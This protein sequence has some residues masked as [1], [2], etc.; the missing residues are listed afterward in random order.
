MPKF[1]IHWEHGPCAGLDVFS[2]T[3]KGRTRPAENAPSY[4][5]K[6][7]SPFRATVRPRTQQSRFD[8]TL[9]RSVM[10][11]LHR[12]LQFLGGRALEHNGFEQQL[13]QLQRLG[14]RLYV[15]FQDDLDSDWQ[16]SGLFLELGL[17]IELL[18]CPWELMFNGS[19][20]LCLRHSPGR[21]INKL[22]TTHPEAEDATIGRSVTSVGSESDPEERLSLL[23]ISVPS[24]LE[25]NGKSYADLEW[26]R[27]E[28]S[29]IQS[30]AKNLKK[31]V[32]VTLLEE[33]SGRRA[34]GGNLRSLLSEAKKLDK[35]Y[36]I[37]HFSGHATYNDK[38]RNR[39]A[40]VLEDE[41]FTTG[42]LHTYLDPIKPILFFANCCEGARIE[43]TPGHNVF[44]LA[45]D[46]LTTGCY[47][48][49]SRW[50]L[51]DNDAHLFAT[52]FYR[53]LLRDNESIGHSV[54]I[55]RQK[56]IDEENNSWASYVYYGDPRTSFKLID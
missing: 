55:A 47:F 56:C 14:Q 50:S 53:A 23:L 3:A 46:I 28:S 26:V 22:P 35:K 34:T 2:P 45:S 43:T 38:M 29:G 4:Y 17:D 16:H 19:E 20:F 18:T 8:P 1:N 37:I 41:D 44:D 12:T 33:S 40:L 11:E 39:S 27:E 32:D 6:Y 49:G 31:N 10:D 9:L 15:P 51:R 5:F 36:H 52:E 54:R 30:I 13:E 48:L 21:F 25:R 7:N 42:E 24:P